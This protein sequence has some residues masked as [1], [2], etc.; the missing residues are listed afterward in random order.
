MKL[1][2]MGNLL[3]KSHILPTWYAHLSSTST[4]VLWQKIDRS[5]RRSYQLQGRNMQ[6][7]NEAGNIL[8]EKSCYSKQLA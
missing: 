2:V 3:S 8:L 1:Q 6:L 7:A 5:V 4:M